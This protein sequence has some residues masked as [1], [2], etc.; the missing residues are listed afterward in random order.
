YVLNDDAELRLNFVDE[1]RAMGGDARDITRC[2]MTIGESLRGS[3]R[4]GRGENS[5]FWEAETERCLYNAVRALEMGEGKVKAMD[6]Q[7]FIGT[8]PFDEAS[9]SSELWQSW[10]HNQVMR[11]AFHNLKTADDATDFELLK[12]YWCGEF[13]SLSPNTRSCIVT[14]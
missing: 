6:I 7:Q 4:K 5:D 9:K 8:A 12:T 13:C 1:V 14:S 3:D 2:I 10:F 11:K